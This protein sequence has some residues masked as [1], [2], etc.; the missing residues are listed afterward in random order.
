MYISRALSA[1]T[2]AF[3]NDVLAYNFQANCSDEVAAGSCC[4]VQHAPGYGEGSVCCVQGDPPYYNATPSTDVDEC[5]LFGCADPISSTITTC[6]TSLL[7][8]RTCK[9][10]GWYL[11][12]GRATDEALLAGDAP[13]PGCIYECPQVQCTRGQY[14]ALEYELSD[15]NCEICELCQICPPGQY[16]IGPGCD[17]MADY[18]TVDCALCPEGYYCTNNRAFECG[19]RVYCPE[20]SS[21]PKSIDEGYYGSGCGSE[22]GS[23]CSFTLTDQSLCKAGSWQAIPVLEVRW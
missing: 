7:N 21:E 14:R 1:G 19:V 16:D 10:P 2:E 9:C 13:F 5:A 20:G 4:T 22:D 3:V 8:Y 11:V 15:G 12:Q 6:S 23:R 18:D 17:G